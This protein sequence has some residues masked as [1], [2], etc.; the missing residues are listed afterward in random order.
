MENKETSLEP[1]TLS[2]EEINPRNHHNQKVKSY[3]NLQ[4]EENLQIPQIRSRA[5]SQF[6]NNPT[7]YISRESDSDES[8]TDA[9]VS[10][11][12]SNKT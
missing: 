11:I 7:H 10:R 5:K 2:Y 9:D 3:V 12:T 8:Q 4:A 6:S 1:I